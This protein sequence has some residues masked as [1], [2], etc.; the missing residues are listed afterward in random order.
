M[1]SSP[2][3]TSRSLVRR[4]VSSVL[5]ALLVVVGLV[6]PPANAQTYY[7]TGDNTTSNAWNAAAGLGGTN[8]SL[9]PDFNSGSPGLP[10]ASDDVF[11]Y[12]N[13]SPNPANLNN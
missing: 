5:A 9:S 3:R 13:P 12:F 4:P 6:A 11:F 10:G 8:W 2:M 7:W 1:R